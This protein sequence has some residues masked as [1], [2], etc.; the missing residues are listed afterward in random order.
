[1]ELHLFTSIPKKAFLS[2]K[3]AYL[4][5]RGSDFYNADMKVF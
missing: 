2:S 4:E 3:F 1:M 5:D